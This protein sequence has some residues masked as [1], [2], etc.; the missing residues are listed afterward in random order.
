MPC[1]LLPITST[2]LRVLRKKE[3]P[4]CSTISEEVVVEREAPVTSGHKKT[5]LSNAVVM[6]PE[7]NKI[8][9]YRLTSFA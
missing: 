6:T 9:Q 4:E 1:S 5:A 7:V 3:C 8:S 2:I